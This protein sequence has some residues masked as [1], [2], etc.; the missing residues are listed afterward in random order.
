[1][2]L[3]WIVYFWEGAEICFGI[4]FKAEYSLFFT[5]H[6]QA[7]SETSELY[8]LHDFSL[9]SS[10]VGFLPEEVNSFRDRKRMRNKGELISTLDMH[11]RKIIIAG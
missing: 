7:N 10:H 5:Y 4:D 3:N 1:M 8:Y 2:F 6:L 9:N 11:L